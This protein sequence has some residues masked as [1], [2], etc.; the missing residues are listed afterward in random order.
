MRL[1]RLLVAS[2]CSP[3][4][5]AATSAPAA[6]PAPRPA[7][8][9]AGRSPARRGRR[10][11]A[12]PWWSRAAAIAS[13]VGRDILRQGG[14]AVDAAVAVG[15]ALA[16]VHPEAG[17]LGGGG[18]M[19]IRLGD[20]TV[21]ALDY[22]ET[23]PARATRDMYLDAL[24]SPPSGASPATSPPACPGAVAG[25]AEAHRRFGQLP[26][27]AVIEPA[28]R[29]ARDGFLVDEYRSQSIA[30]DSA[31]LALF[32]ASRASF[33]PDGAPPAPG[34]DAPPARPRRDPRGDPGPRRRRL[35]PGPGRRSDRRG[36]GARRRAHL[37]RGPR[38]LP[39]DLARADR[40]HYRGL[41]DLLDAAG[42]VGRR[43][44]G[45]DP[46]HHGRLRPAAAL[47]LA[48]AA[49]TSRPR[50]C[51]A[52]SPTA[53]PT[54]AIRPSCRIPTDRLLSQEPTPPSSGRASA[55][56]PRRRPAFAPGRAHGRLDH[57][58]LGR[59]RRGQRRE[60]HDDAQRQLR[61][62]GDGDRRGL[63]AERRDGRLRHGA[64][65]AEHVRPGA[66]RGQRDRAGQAHALGDDAEHRAR[67]RRA[68]CCWW[69]AR[70]AARASSRWCTT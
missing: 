33:L 69:S 49:C 25:L 35:L 66:G 39:G 52:R 23:A 34:H 5:P 61:Q 12:A 70:P 63:P 43:H 6:R 64:G 4:R 8:R 46:Q 2:P 50:P 31:R 15:F 62:R 29:L 27:A 44:D 14:N 30:G 47:R 40:L 13:E 1:H 60:L 36:D 55:S 32:P 28:I 65:Q 59:G 9:P 58:L 37:A 16:V 67:S 41:H 7:S 68:G 21:H 17:N 22:R 26:F 18:F 45:R 56:A 19:V 38:E 57:A 51:G 10:G 24:A 3:S 11:R 20:G 54:S 53:T 42:L 48:R